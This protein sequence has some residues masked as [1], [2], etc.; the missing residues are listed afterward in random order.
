MLLSRMSHQPPDCLLKPLESSRAAQ[1]P[2]KT[3]L[4][5]MDV[6][7]S[8]TISEVEEVVPLQVIT[9]SQ[10]HGDEKDH[11]TSTKNPLT[12]TKRKTQSWRVKSKCN[13]ESF[14]IAKQSAQEQEGETPAQQVV[15]TPW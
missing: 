4:N 1:P 10:V 13:R 14:H 9:R 2:L 7:P 8:P 15:A 3:A 11:C 5:L 12:Q 6:I